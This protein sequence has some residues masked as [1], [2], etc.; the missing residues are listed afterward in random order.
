VYRPAELVATI[1]RSIVMFTDV[2]TSIGDG[3]LVP[4]G[5]RLFESWRL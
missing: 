2:T 1:G 3:V 5:G 4:P